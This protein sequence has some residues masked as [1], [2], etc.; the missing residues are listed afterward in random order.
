MKKLPFVIFVFIML[1]AL[2]SSV[3]SYKSTEN[4][5]T[6]DVNNALKLTLA[7]MPTNVVNADTIRCYRSHLTIAELKD[8]ACIAMT[9]V[10]KAGRQETQMVAQA[11]CDFMTIL[12]LS[13]QRAS[14]ALLFAGILWMMCSLWYIRRFKPEMFAKGLSFGGIVFANDKF[15]TAK[16][17][18]IHFTPMQHSLM[19]MFMKTE[20]HSLSKQEICDRLWPKKPD[21]SD[22]LYTLIKRVK[23]ILEANSNLKI[24]SDRGKCYTLELK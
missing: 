9:S 13:D 1:S 22:T 4:R 15:I 6:R 19:E 12:M 2:C 17:K 11:N 10:I 21:A 20:S 3:G 5:I 23:P 8:T 24:E 7:E 18:P 14:G 16:G